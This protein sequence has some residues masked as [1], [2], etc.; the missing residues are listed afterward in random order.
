M[1]SKS[2]FF[3]SKYQSGSDVLFF[4]ISFHV[5]G[6]VEVLK[7]EFSKL[8]NKNEKTMRHLVALVKR[9]I[10][11]LNLVKM[12][13]ETISPVLVVQLFFSCILICA[14]GEQSYILSH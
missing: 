7:L 11:L 8:A 6:Q 12:L 14:S 1:V 5:C 10:D 2:F 4:G 3:V 9:H 13:N